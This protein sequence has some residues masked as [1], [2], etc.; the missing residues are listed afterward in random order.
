MTAAPQPPLPLPGRE[1]RTACGGLAKFAPD[2]PRILYNERWVFFCLPVCQ[3]EFKQNPATSCYGPQ[4][5][6][7]EG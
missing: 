1:V 7:E 6:S 4:I 2:S 3:Q 5:V